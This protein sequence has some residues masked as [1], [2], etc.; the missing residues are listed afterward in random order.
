MDGNNQKQC[1]ECHKTTT[2][3]DSDGAQFNVC[4]ECGNI[5][6]VDETDTA[7]DSITRNNSFRFVPYTFGALYGII[8]LLIF[9]FFGSNIFACII[10]VFIAG[11]SWHNIKIGLRGSQRLIDEMCLNRDNSLSDEANTEL[12]KLDKLD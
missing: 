7:S 2:T 10:A 9:W 1:L 11:Y 12:R 8:A 4:R 3:I 6:Y 5:S